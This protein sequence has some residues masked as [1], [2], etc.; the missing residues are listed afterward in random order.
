MD[1]APTIA[2][3]YMNRLKRGIK[4]QA[5]PTVIYAVGDF[6]IRRVLNRDKQVDSPYN[7]YKYRG[8]PPGP[9]NMPSIAALN[10]VLNHENHNYLYF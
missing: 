5:D 6:S 10:S 4:L 8:L 1:E 9:I 7:T 3:V 2:G